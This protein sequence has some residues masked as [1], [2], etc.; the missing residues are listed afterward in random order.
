MYI[1]NIIFLCANF[2]SFSKILKYIFTHRETEEKTP[3][4]LQISLLYSHL[5]Q[6]K[7]S[8]KY[9]WGNGLVCISYNMYYIKQCFKRLFDFKLFRRCRLERYII[10]KKSPQFVEL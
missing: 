2:L 1:G 9:F 5:S 8:P 7:C 4:T 10:T 6:L 3:L